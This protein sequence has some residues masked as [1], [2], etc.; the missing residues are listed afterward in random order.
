[1]SLSPQLLRPPTL[2]DYQYQGWTIKT[3]KSRIMSSAEEADINKDL[4]LPHL[5]DMLFIHNRLTLQHKD[6]LCIQ[7][8]PKDALKRVN[9]KEDLIHVSLSKDWLAARQNSPH[10]NKIVH[11]YDWTFTT[12]YKGT[13]S[14]QGTLRVEETNETIDYEQL[15]VK[16]KIL[17]FDELVL[18]EDELDDNGCTKLSVKIRAMPSGFFVLLRFY[19]RVDNTLIRLHDTRLYHQIG[20][21]FVLREYSEREDRTENLSV[22]RSLWTDQNQIVDHLTLKTATNHKI[23]L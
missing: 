21:D 1:M 2:D 4:E 12:D 5:P 20:T 14:H 8:N 16:E 11:P 18:F 13:T 10:I 23:F 7:M 17:F 3:A 19:L 9:N 15:K 6:G 22:D